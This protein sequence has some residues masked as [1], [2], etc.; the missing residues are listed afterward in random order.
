M[1]FNGSLWHAIQIS[2]RG[3]ISSRGR[4]SHWV[5]EV[6]ADNSGGCSAAQRGS[7]GTDLNVSWCSLVQKQVTELVF[8]ID[9]Q[10]SSCLQTEVLLA[11]NCFS[12]FQIVIARRLLL[13]VAV[14]RLT[15][16]P[17]IG[18]WSVLLFASVI[19]TLKKLM[20]AQDVDRQDPV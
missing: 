3:K 19:L 6:P 11:V 18:N 13:T 1:A 16:Q 5:Q 2:F 4:D 9:C 10:L 20:E 12:S 15:N 14:S 7:K 8:A 17:E